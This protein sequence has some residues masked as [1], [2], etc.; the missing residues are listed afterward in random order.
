MKQIQTGISRFLTKLY[1]SSQK[2]NNIYDIARFGNFNLNSLYP[3]EL[4]KELRGENVFVAL[5][6]MEADDFKMIAIDIS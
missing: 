1:K 3:M 5:E 2:I 4:I 6:F